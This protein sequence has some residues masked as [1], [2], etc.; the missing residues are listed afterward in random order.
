[1]LRT[2]T[3][4]GALWASMLAAACGLD[5]SGGEGG[6]SDGSGSSTGGSAS[7]TASSTDSTT[8]S[9]SAST[10][11]STTASTTASTSSADSGSE[12]G[13]TTIDTTGTGTTDATTTGTDTGGSSGGS[14]SGGMPEIEYPPCMADD[15][16]TDPY[17]LCWPPQRFGDP[18]FCTLPCGNADECP[19]APTGGAV[20]VCEG[21]PDQNICVLDCTDADC[22]DGMTCI[23]VFGNGD[24]MRCTW[25]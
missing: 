1:M 16:C 7:A 10:S 11:A 20:P 25:V 12:T 13:V 3:S 19:L 17:S 6:S 24:F 21:P 2:W 5:S 15:E 22:P 8:A 9:T 23:D 14:S 18:A 4:Y